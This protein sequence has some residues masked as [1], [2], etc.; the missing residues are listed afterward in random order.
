MTDNL[1]KFTTRRSITL[2]ARHVDVLRETLDRLRLEV[3]ELRASRE[4]LVLAA[5]ADRRRIERDLHD[6]PQQQLVALAVNLQLARQLADADPAAAKAL[7][8]EIGRDVRQALDETGRLA[9]R[10]YP[11]LLEAGGLATALRAA[12]L[13]AGIPTRIEV[14]AGASASPE[15]AGAVYFCCLDVLERAGDEARVTV[16]VRGD[17]G[18]LAF[19]VVAHGTGSAPTALGGV[20]GRLRDRVEALGGQL[21]VQSQPGQ[22]IRIAGSLPLSR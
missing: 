8:K 19:E 15:V 21:T 14:T 13:S 7:L 10:I 22:A 4:R 2:E 18:A 6:G 16:T 3:A 12:A 11:P 5:D 17:D 20:L 9:Q 1:G